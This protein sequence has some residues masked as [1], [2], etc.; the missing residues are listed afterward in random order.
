[1]SESFRTT[2]IYLILVDF[3]ILTFANPS[4][5][6]GDANVKINPL[7]PITLRFSISILPYLRA[8]NRRRAE[9]KTFRPEPVISRSGDTHQLPPRRTNAPQTNDQSL[10]PIGR[11]EGPL[12]GVGQSVASESIDRAR[13]FAAGPRDQFDR[14][15][16]QQGQR[17]AGGGL[18]A[19][20]AVS[21][22]AKHLPRR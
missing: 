2:S 16:H 13:C 18:H 19:A 9:A 5:P 20:P 12:T 17:C 3:T 6:P 1:M 4:H 22:V 10:L 21:G 11:I 15:A 7:V 8:R 14:A